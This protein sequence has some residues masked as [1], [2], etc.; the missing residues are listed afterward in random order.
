[1][2]ID[3][4]VFLTDSIKC[5][6][7]RRFP[8][9][10]H[11]INSIC[12][13]ADES[14]LVSGSY[15]CSVRI[16]DLKSQNR[17]PIQTLLDA[18]D[19]ISK[20]I[21][22]QEKIISISIDGG[23]RIYDIRMGHMIK[24]DLEISLNG[25]DNS[26]DEKFLGISGTDDCLRLMESETGQI[27]KVFAGLHKSKNYAKT[28]KFSKENDGIFISSENND[29]VFYDLVDEKKDK[30]LRGHSKVTSG[31]DIHPKDKNLLV[32]CGFDCN[33]MLWD[34]NPKTA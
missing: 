13:N 14:V 9:H 4:Q 22:L 26:H 21:A 17:E 34:L 1:V 24:D 25:I 10:L 30:I 6:V 23:L 11:T 31:L 5:N 7:L 19:S 3:K 12:F 29:V 20:V 27:I 8:G 16:W 28:V 2:G 33:I 32:T 18:K 15:D